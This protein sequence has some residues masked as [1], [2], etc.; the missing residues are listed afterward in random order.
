MKTLK[1]NIHESLSVSLRDKLIALINDPSLDNETAMKMINVGRWNDKTLGFKASE[2]NDNIVADTNKNGRQYIDYVFRNKKT[3]EIKTTTDKELS[4]K[5]WELVSKTPRTKIEKAAVFSDKYSYIKDRLNILGVDKNAQKDIYTRLIDAN[6]MDRYSK[7][8]ESPTIDT[9]ALIKG[10]NI[11][12]LFTKTGLNK[13]SLFGISQYEAKDTKGTSL[14]KYEILLKLLLSDYIG[15]ETSPG[16][17]GRGDVITKSAAIEIKVDGGRAI[18]QAS[19]DPSKIK[20]YLDQYCDAP[21][22]P[23]GGVTYAEETMKALMSKNL[24]DEEISN[25]IS[26]SMNIYYGLN[27]KMSKESFKKFIISHIYELRKKPSLLYRIVACYQILEYQR[28]EKWDYLILIDKISGDYTVFDSSKF[29]QDNVNSYDILY[30]NKHLGFGKG[31][32]SND[33]RSKAIG[34]VYKK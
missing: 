12:S 22:N 27:A 7:Y 24:S 4:L 23:F 26:S 2:Y 8:I 30:D 18:N 10:S 21:T 14:G 19:P 6:M 28:S 1:N 33:T 34:L 11:F 25:I 31:I 16:T 9:D 3:G 32:I 29:N 20:S 13:R 15:S 5:N 17:G